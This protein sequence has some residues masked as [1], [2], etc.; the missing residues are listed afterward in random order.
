MPANYYA[1]AAPAQAPAAPPES[2]P[3]PSPREEEKKGAATTVIPKEVLGSYEC[4]PGEKITLEVVQVN[5]DSV[6]ARKAEDEPEPAEPPPE[7][8]VGSNPLYE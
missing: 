2:K 4:K 3:A 7:E 6:V 1:D 8:G 5:E